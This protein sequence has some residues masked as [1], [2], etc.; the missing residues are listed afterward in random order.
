MIVAQV[1]ITRTIHMFCSVGGGEVVMK[2]REQIFHEI[3]VTDYN[4]FL[5]KIIA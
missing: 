1:P 2:G 4:S 3:C 5:L